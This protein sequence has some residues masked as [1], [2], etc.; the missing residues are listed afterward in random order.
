[1]P[2]YVNQN[3]THL[4]HTIFEHEAI[5]DVKTLAPLIKKAEALYVEKVGQKCQKS[6]TPS[7]RMSCLCLGVAISPMSR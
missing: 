2:S 5:K 6:F 4:N 3:L 1:M 7:G